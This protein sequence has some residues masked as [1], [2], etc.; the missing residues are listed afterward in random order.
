MFANLVGNP[1]RLVQLVVNCLAVGGAFL[2]GQALTAAVAWLIDRQLTGGKSPHGAKRAARII[3][4]CI[5]AVLTALILFGHGEGWT[6][7]GGGTP[8]DANGSPTTPAT[9]QAESAPTTAPKPITPPATR[10]SVPV[11]DRVRITL[12]GGDDVKNERF[13]LFDADPAAKTFDEV[14]AALAAKKEATAGALGVEVR[15]AE[16][17]PLPAN[18]PAVLRLT[19][20]ATAHG[21]A[22]TLPAGDDKVT[23]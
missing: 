22:V 19:G 6:V 5:L 12:L 8:G 2:L 10:P 16:A 9:G 3:G 23:R 18:H 20:W 17:N 11:A 4:G 1:E 15:L 13:Y 21:L 7:L 14:K